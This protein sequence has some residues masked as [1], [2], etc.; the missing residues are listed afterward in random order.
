MSPPCKFLTL[1]SDCLDR[2]PSEHFATRHVFT[3]TPLV[4]APPS[5]QPHEEALVSS[6]R[7]WALRET[8]VSPK[9][10]AWGLT[11]GVWAQVSSAPESRV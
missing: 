10:R 1:V 4:L 3:A 2:R 8:E 11:Q 6:A 9:D 7:F 5:Q